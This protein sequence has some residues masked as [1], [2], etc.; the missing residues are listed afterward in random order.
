[1]ESKRGLYSSDGGERRTKT[2]NEDKE[3]V[4]GSHDGTQSTSDLPPKK[5]SALNQISA[6]RLSLAD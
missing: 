3:Y 2:G 4:Q 6:L 5:A 1:M